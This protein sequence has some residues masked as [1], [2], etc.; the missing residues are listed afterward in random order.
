MKILK[1]E[2]AIALFQLA[3]IMAIAPFI[4]VTSYLA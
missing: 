1:R 3:G 2:H 4:I